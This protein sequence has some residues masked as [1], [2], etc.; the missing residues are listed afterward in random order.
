MRRAGAIDTGFQLRLLGDYSRQPPSLPHMQIHLASG[1]AAFRV[2][3]KLFLPHQDE[4]YNS[5]LWQVDRQAAAHRRPHWLLLALAHGVL[6]A[7]P[8]THSELVWL[9]WALLTA[10]ISE[11]SGMLQHPAVEGTSQAAA[12][13]EVC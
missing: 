8:A 10:S 3:S 2:T 7:P 6:K 12:A 11:F 9:L 5:K 13:N 4:L 1:S